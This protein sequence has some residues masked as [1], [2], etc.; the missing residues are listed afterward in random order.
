MQENLDEDDFD[1]DMPM[2][3]EHADEP[4]SSSDDSSYEGFSDYEE[5]CYYTDIVEQ[6]FPDEDT[7]GN[8]QTL[9]NCQSYQPTVP[10]SET[11]HKA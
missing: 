8:Y 11:M 5:Y 3:L 10:C 9:K 6:L 4:D 1:S 7:Q 2:L